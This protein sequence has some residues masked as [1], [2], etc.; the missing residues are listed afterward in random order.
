[1]SHHVESGCSQ[2]FMLSGIN[3][4]AKLIRNDRSINGRQ[5]TSTQDLT[6][7]IELENGCACE[8]VAS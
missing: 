2:M 8:P 5:Y 7:T 4:D 6:D 1:M 3:I